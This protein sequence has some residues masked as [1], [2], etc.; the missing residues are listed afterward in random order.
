MLRKHMVL[1]RI[2]RFKDSRNHLETAEGIVKECKELNFDKDRLD[3]T[4]DYADTLRELG[5]LGLAESRLYSEIKRRDDA[6]CISGKSRL[7]LTLAEV[8]L[9]SGHIEYTENICLNVQ[10]RGGLL[11]F[12]RLRF[13]IT[14]AKIRHSMSDNPGTSI[15]LIKA[16]TEVRKCT[17]TNGYTT[18]IIMLSSYEVLPNMAGAHAEASRKEV[19]VL[20]GHATPGGTKHWI[21]GQGHWAQS[22]GFTEIID[23]PIPSTEEGEK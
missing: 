6:Y 13:Q 22:R 16:L 10:C 20:G 17:L 9:A 1:G 4:C 14:I 8:L 18:R 5:E 19:D 12:E 7:E 21:A 11:K 2:L 23:N 15:S 3:L